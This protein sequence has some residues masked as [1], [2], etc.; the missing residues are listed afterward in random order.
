MGFVST[1]A[2]KII[3]ADAC[4]HTWHIKNEAFGSEI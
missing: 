1:E 2:K 4:K 3:K